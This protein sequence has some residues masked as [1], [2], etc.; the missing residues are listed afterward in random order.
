MIHIVCASKDGLSNQ[1]W[2]MMSRFEFIIPI[3]FATKNKVKKDEYRAIE[4]KFWDHEYS[5]IC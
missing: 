3:L 2:F 5:Q 1:S 4:S